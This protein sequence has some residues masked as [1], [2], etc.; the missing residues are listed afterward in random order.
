MSRAIVVRVICE[1][2]FYIQVKLYSVQS[3]LLYDKHA[4]V[5][6]YLRYWS[7]GKIHCD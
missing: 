3:V 2:A 5:Y 4:C 7:E 6:E 1:F